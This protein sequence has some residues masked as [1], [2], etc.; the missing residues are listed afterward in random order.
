MSKSTLWL[1]FVVMA[2]AGCVSSNRYGSATKEPA[3]PAAIRLFN[4]ED[5]TGWKLFLPDEQAAPEATWAVR[6]HAICCTGTPTG[7]LR[8]LRPYADYRL[9]FE[10]RWPSG[11][12]GNSGVLLHIQAPDK[13]WPKSIESQLQH[14][15]GG[16]FYVIGGTTFK[17]HVNKEER[18][19]AKRHT[20]NEKPL[21]EWNTKEIVCQGDSITVYVNGRLQNQATEATVSEGYIGFQSE[22]TPIE[23]RNITLELLPAS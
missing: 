1:A 22:G 12:G 7:Y 3:R 21:G 16:D 18:R 11:K 20:S 8:T 13:V 5:F 15:N 4:G 23:F 17:E 6:D 14:E 19:V 10:W 2:M 9:R